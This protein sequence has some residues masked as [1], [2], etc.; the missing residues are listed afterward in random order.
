M[1]YQDETKEFWARGSKLFWGEFLR[2]MGGEELACRSM[3][4]QIPHD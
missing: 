4:R 1:K 3:I 2:F